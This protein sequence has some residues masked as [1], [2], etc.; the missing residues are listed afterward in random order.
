MDIEL[1]SKVD[2]FNETYKEMRKTFYFDGKKLNMVKALSAVFESNYSDVDRVRKIKKYIYKSKFD[3]FAI[4]YGRF[5]SHFLCDSKDYKNIFKIS[6]KIYEHLTMTGFSKSRTTLAFSIILSKRYSI[7]KLNEVVEK[8]VAIKKD[9]KLSS[10]EYYI[11][12]ALIKGDV[13]KIKDE[14]NNTKKAIQSLEGY[15]EDRSTLLALS[16]LIGD[17]DINTKVENAF[18]LISNIKEEMGKISEECFVFIGLASLIAEDNETFAKELKEVFS[19]FVKDNR[20]VFNKE[21]I[22]VLSLAILICRYIEEA[23]AGVTNSK[24]DNKYLKIIQDYII[25]LVYFN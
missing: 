11:L 13:E 1:K 12:L 3:L 15:G 10:E 5:I 4:K 22:M 20:E 19:L 25:F 18:S 9:I 6:K 24:I 16:I 2:I 7:D 23:E 21:I 8:A 17:E 14:L